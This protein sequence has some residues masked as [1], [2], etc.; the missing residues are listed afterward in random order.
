MNIVGIDHHK[1]DVD[2]GSLN[3]KVADSDR[4]KYQC[5]SQTA[6]YDRLA[7]RV[8]KEQKPLFQT[9][10]AEQYAPVRVIF[11]R[12]CHERYYRRRAREVVWEVEKNSRGTEGK[13]AGAQRE[14]VA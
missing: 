7:Q 13:I 5:S 10:R 1:D 9:K 11:H 4:M 12:L 3:D 6:L 8:S 2:V 14:K